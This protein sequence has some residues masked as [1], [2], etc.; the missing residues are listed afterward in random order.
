MSYLLP[1]HIKSVIE[2]EDITE[3]FT[4][5]NGHPPKERLLRVRL[6]SDCHGNVEEK[7]KVFFASE[8]EIAK[9]NNYF[10]E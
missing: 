1:Y 8:W 2:E 7:T 10:L 6:V 3:A 9:K 5:H 4:K